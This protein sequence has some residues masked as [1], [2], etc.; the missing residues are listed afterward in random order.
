MII[1][2]AHEA[3]LFRRYKVRL[4]ADLHHVVRVDRAQEAH[5]HEGGLKAADVEAIWN[6][7]QALYRSAAYPAIQFALRRRGQLLMHRALGHAR[8]NGPNDPLHGPRPLLRLDTPVCLFSASKAVTAVLVHQ[9]AEEGGLELDQRVSHYLPA[10]AQH[11]KRETTVSDVL[12]HHGGFPSLRVPPAQKRVETLA[13]WDYVVDS[14]CRAPPTRS[15]QMAYHAISGG[16]ILGEL[17][18]RITGAP[19]ADYLDRKLRQPL[20]MKYF[21]YGLPPAYRSEMALNYVAGQ[22][23][24]FPVAPLIANALTAPFEDVVEASNTAV[25]MDAVIPAGNMFAT[26]EELSRFFQMLLDGGRWQ[27]RQ[28]LK[29]ETVERA[30]RPRG[31]MNLD[32]TLMIPMRYSDG[33]MLGADPV[34]LFGPNTG[35]AFGHLGFMNILGW[36]DPQRQISVALL[37]TGKAVLGSHLVALSRLLGEISQRCAGRQR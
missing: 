4:P 1:R 33:M 27:H 16:F 28:I 15:R 19:L 26:A 22:A 23:V 29:S 25:F 24:R 8:G 6:A 10:F 17:I 35:S 37:T 9:L 21:S 12:S 34:G 14:I 2:A 7:L 11:G 20:G 31:R 32:R 36:A 5:A 13:Q 30:L 3:G 18:Q